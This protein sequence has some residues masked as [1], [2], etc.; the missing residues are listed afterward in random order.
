MIES[1]S[2]LILQDRTVFS[3]KEFAIV[4]LKCL[5][6][7]SRQVPFIFIIYIYSIYCQNKYAKY[8][9]NFRRTVDID[10]Y[11]YILLFL[12]MIFYKTNSLKQK[13]DIIF[14]A[15]YPPHLRS[16]QEKIGA[17][18]SQKTTKLCTTTFHEIKK[19]SR[20]WPI[21]SSKMVLGSFFRP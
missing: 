2:L 10:K 18:S 17:F 3:P 11:L 12:W 8:I 21:L 9:H 19:F 15:F 5:I 20:V 14:T 4:G 13:Y 7:Y 6:F 16:F 1:E